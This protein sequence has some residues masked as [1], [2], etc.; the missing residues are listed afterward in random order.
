M[1]SKATLEN[2]EYLSYANKLTNAIRRVNITDTPKACGGML[3]AKKHAEF[4]GG[5][6]NL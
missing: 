3:C 4:A 2:N 5:V 1:K 6:V